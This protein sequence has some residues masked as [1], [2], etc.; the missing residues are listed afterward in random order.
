MGE[1]FKGSTIAAG[2][3]EGYTGNTVLYHHG[4]T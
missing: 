2:Q 4:P 3:S 1:R